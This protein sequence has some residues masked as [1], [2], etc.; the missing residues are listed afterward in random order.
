MNRMDPGLLTSSHVIRPYLLTLCYC[1]YCPSNLLYC[2][3]LWNNKISLLV[4]STFFLSFLLHVINLIPDNAYLPSRASTNFNSSSSLFEPSTIASLGLLCLQ[5]YLYL[6]LTFVLNRTFALEPRHHSKENLLNIAPN[7]NDVLLIVFSRTNIPLPQSGHRRP[8]T[9]IMASS[10]FNMSLRIAIQNATD[11]RDVADLPYRLVRPI[12]KKITNP[13]Q[14]A[15]IEEVSPHIADEDAELWHIF[16]KRDIPNGE[17]MIPL[18]TPTNPR[19]WSKVYRKLKRADERSRNAAEE[20]LK[21][22]LAGRKEEKA[23]NQSTIIHAVIPQGKRGVANG[24]PRS[25]PSGMQALKNAKTS[26]DKLNILR[27]QAGNATAGRTQALSTPS[28]QLAQMR[29]SV[30]QAPRF[31][32]SQYE[33]KPPP[34]VQPRPPQTVHR[35]TI[36]VSRTGPTSASDRAI[37][38]ALAREKAAEKERKLRA[39]TG[40]ASTTRPTPPTTSAT[41]PTQSTMSTTRPTQPTTSTTRPTQPPTTTSHPTPAVNA[42]SQPAAAKRSPPRIPSPVKAL[43]KRPV[44][45]PMVPNKR[46]KI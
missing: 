44:Y 1:P 32:V 43:R 18:N 4:A 9:N 13:A 8:T 41:R 25:L 30:Q 39:L 46:R 6:H 45:D 28:H 23:K 22:A 21:A 12:L 3:P 7:N 42:P 15:E 38:A 17:K 27:R 20:Q 35:P 34:A 26:A 5:Q 16:I 31:M 40:G 24:G 37:N 29:G 19:S 10:L 2:D 33:R 36:F 11:I 14:L